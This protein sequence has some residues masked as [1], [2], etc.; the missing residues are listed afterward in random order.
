MKKLLLVLFVMAVAFSNQ[1]GWLEGSVTLRLPAEGIKQ[2]E[3]GA[4]EYV[5]DGIFYRKLLILIRNAFQSPISKTFHF[6]PFKLYRTTSSPFSTIST[7]SPS[8]PHM[9]RLFSEVYNSEAMIQEHEKIMISESKKFQSQH[10]PR[11]PTPENV[12]AAI[13]LWSDATH[14]ASFGTA[15]L[16]PVYPF[17]GNQS[18]YRRSKPTM[19]A[20]HHLAYLPNL[21]PALQEFYKKT[22]G[23]A[24]SSATLTHLKRELM[25]AHAYKHG[26]I[27]ECGDEKRAKVRTDTEWR[28]NKIELVRTFIFNL[29][30]AIASTFVNAFSEKLAKVDFNFYSMFVPDLLHEFELGVWKATFTHLL[31]VLYAAAGDRIQELNKRLQ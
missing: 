30:Y 22:F 20:A 19:F 26:I 4:P 25:Q 14:L 3:S 18:K 9:Q 2:A 23:I 8:T 6:V 21:P 1:D 17:F 13:L 28:R 27:I 15:S 29:G 31:R 7:S 12:V 24:A 16:W 5:V 11:V 10:D